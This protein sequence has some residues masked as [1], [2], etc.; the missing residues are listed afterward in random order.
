MG[1]HLAHV[2]AY[3]KLLNIIKINE[4]LKALIPPP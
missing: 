4:R 2:F 3:K 1:N